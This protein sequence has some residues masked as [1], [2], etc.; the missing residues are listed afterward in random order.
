MLHVFRCFR[1][2]LHLLIRDRREQSEMIK[3]CFV[4]GN[5]KA[6]PFALTDSYQSWVHGMMHQ[7]KLRTNVLQIILNNKLKKLEKINS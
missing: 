2:P 4:A 5:L 6:L 1:V 3:T 7:A